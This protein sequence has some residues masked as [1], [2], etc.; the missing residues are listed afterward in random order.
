MWSEGHRLLI[1]ALKIRPSFSRIEKFL[2]L[3]QFL[4]HL[5]STLLTFCFYLKETNSGMF[6]T[7]NLNGALYPL[8]T[9]INHSCRPNSK[10]VDTKNKLSEV[11][12]IPHA[13]H[14]FPHPHPNPSHFLF[15]FAFRYVFSVMGGLL[16]TD[17][18]HHEGGYSRDA[19]NH[20]LLRQS[21]LAWRIKTTDLETGLWL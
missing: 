8:H 18:S 17:N 7:N 12:G 5:G 6:N 3:D 20:N 4:L 10:A 1:A 15:Y 9:H 19:R 21:R 11:T 2:T 14:P 13:L 16:L